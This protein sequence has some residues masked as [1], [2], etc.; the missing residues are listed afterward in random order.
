MPA[1]TS[2]LGVADVLAVDL[3]LSTDSERVDDSSWLVKNMSMFIQRAHCCHNCL[4]MYEDIIYKRSTANRTSMTVIY[5]IQ[6]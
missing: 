3:L 1:F 5:T 6:K 4:Q 2:F